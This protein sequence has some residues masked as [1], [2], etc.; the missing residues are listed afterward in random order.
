MKSWLSILERVRSELERRLP[1]RSASENIFLALVPLVGVATGLTAVGIAHVIAFVQK[2]CWQTGP[3][4]LEAAEAQPP[5]YR[6]MV[7]T[8]GGLFVG[9][10]GHWFR[11]E[12]RGA[13][14]AGMIQALA[15]K[16]GFVSLRQTIPRVMAGIATVA[17]GGSLGREGPMSQF[18]G[19]FGSWIARV[20]NL[21]TQQVRILTCAASAASIAAVYNA[22]IGG[23]LLAME[24]LIGS[25]ALEILGPVVIASV[26]STLIFRSAMGDLPRFDIP[27]ALRD[28]YGLASNWELCAYLALGI[29]GGIVSVIFMKALFWSEDIFEKLPL[30]RLVKPA[31]GMMAVGVIGCWYPHVF[32]NGFDAVN[33]LLHEELDLGLLPML[34]VAKLA[35]TALTLGAGG[36]GGLF[37]PTLMMGGLLGGMFGTVLHQW[38]PEQTA[39]HGGYALVGMGAVLAG[40]THAPITAIL[41]IFEQTNSYQTILPLMLVCIISNLV[42][43]MI[44]PRAVHHEILHRRGVVLPSGLEE[45]VMKNLRVRDVMHEEVAS[46]KESATFHEVVDYFL[47]APHNFLYVTVGDDKYFGAIPLQ[48]IKSALRHTDTL[49]SVIAYDLVD[50]TFPFVTE[51]QR[52]SDTMEVFWRQQCERL[53]VVDSV[54]S[55]RL[56]G[57]VSKRDLIGIYNQ[58]IL[59]KRHLLGRFTVTGEGGKEDT[60]VELPEG[61]QLHT[62]TVPAH[63]VGETLRDLSLRTQ[64]NIHVLQIRR[65]NAEAG[66]PTAEMP[67]ADSAISAGDRIIVIGTVVDIA[68]F[69]ADMTQ[70]PTAAS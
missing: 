54:E 33:Q 70:P 56:V 11:V 27:L 63:F 26:I 62:I 41:M 16:G 28:H 10:I 15:L 51:Y 3:H 40:T 64:Y 68:R 37:L 66:A 44:M 30:P 49:D 22:P 65:R 13:G 34:L 7:L 12:T 60:Y 36:A 47:K 32:G 52:L 8:L 21:N 2:F 58:E 31:L 9:V 43:R 67:G 17:S 35:A 25:F 50:D 29:L 57:W 14:T 42:A 38:F 1:R 61:F 59:H 19:A 18:G 45:S 48:S 24:V 4:L 39:T 53:P 20:C 5:Y 69:M 55:R 23:S 46:V 6:I